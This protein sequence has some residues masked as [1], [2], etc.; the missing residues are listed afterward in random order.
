[1][2]HL[3]VWIFGSLPLVDEH[4]DHRLD[5]FRELEV[6]DLSNEIA[7][8]EEDAAALAVSIQGIQEGP[9]A[10]IVEPPHQSILLSSRHGQ[11]SEFLTSYKGV[12]A[13]V[14]GQIGLGVPLQ[15]ENNENIH[16]VH[17]TRSQRING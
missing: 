11:R 15:E 9:K 4:P 5:L 6:R 8:L 1:M 2:L 12:A 13:L 10:K 16:W 14:Q 7:Q 17:E 3:A